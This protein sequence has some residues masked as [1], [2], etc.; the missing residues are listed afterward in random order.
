[1]VY[2]VSLHNL[3]TTNNSE[4][5]SFNSEDDSRHASHNSTSS[6][7]GYCVN[8]GVGYGGDMVTRTTASLLGKMGREGIMF[9]AWENDPRIID[10]HVPVTVW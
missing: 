10:G 6:D 9:P 7:K 5:T 4:E 8:F 2:R 1:V 3:K